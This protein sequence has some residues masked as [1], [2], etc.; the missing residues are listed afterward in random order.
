MYTTLKKC[1]GVTWKIREKNILKVCKPLVI[2]GFSLTEYDDCLEDFI[3]NFLVRYNA[4]YETT[5]LDTMNGSQCAPRRLRSLIDIFLICKHYFP[6]CSLEEVKDALHANEALSSQ[7]CSTVRRR[8]YWCYPN[9]I[10]AVRNTESEDEFGLIY[11]KYK[12]EK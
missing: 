7:V 9:S 3:H 5:T 11:E 2:K 6:E 10:P 4:Q 8:V 12:K 1:P